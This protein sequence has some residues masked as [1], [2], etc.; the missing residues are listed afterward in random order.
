MEVT[1]F[2]GDEAIARGTAEEVTRT[3]G[4][5]LP[6]RDAVSALVFDDETGRLID[7]DYRGVGEAPPRGRG[8]PKL[9]VTAREVTLLPRHWEWLSGQP[10]G[11]SAAIRRLVEEARKAPP[12]PEA[13]RDA[14][15]RF[16]SHLCGDR[17]GYE[18]ALRALYRGER[19]R[20]EALIAPWPADVRGY[21]LRL[22]G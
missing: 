1:A 6:A 20:F 4:A 18:E 2:L 3:L 15:Y 13:R 7:L 16:M 11:A 12:S 8:R 19:E 14:A 9:G 5:E 10:G 22:L 17:A 21:I